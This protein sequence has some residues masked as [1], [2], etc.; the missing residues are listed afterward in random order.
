MAEKLYIVHLKGAQDPTDKAYIQPVHASNVEVS[1]DCLI[2]S[3][4]DGT[5]AAFFD[6]SIVSD[7]RETDQSELP[8]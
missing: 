4:L 2:F 6:M 8:R 3:H 5:L 1:G 7:W